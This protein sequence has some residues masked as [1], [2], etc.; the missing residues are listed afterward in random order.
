[1]LFMVRLTM[2]F[3]FQSVAA[4]A[5]LLKTQF[6]VGLAEIG[7]LIGLYFTPGIVLAL[8]G[9][10]IGQRL[11][12]KRTTLAALL[13]MLFGSMT[14][15][16]GE[17]WSWQV[18][19]RLIAG[20]GGVLL[21]VQMTKMVADWFAGKEIATAMAIFVNSWPAGIALSLLALPSIGTGYG[22]NAVHLFVAALVVIGIA[23]AMIYQP[24]PGV[25]AAAAASARPD[26]RTALVVTVAG[27][28]WGLFNVGFAVVFSFG[29]TMLVER[30]WTIARAGSVISIVLWLAVISVPMGGF[31]A[32]RLKRPQTVLVVGSLISAALMLGLAHTGAVIA[33]VVAL[34]LISGQPAG[35]IMS[36][37]ARVLQPHTRAIGMGVFYAIYYGIM[38]LGPIIAGTCAKWTGEAA[39]AFDFGALV[40]L[41]C[42]PLLWAFNRIAAA[43]TVP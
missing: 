39:S 10:A 4:V 20:G 16:L 21:N 5:P 35:P 17:S 1:M 14:M 3:Q 18:A 7:F 24:P 26:F 13:L 6:S 41:A 25:A 9:G 36:L 2:A 32:D 43:R 29:P 33:G 19:G 12:D 42:P 8:P 40:M 34:G 11:G 22:I 23:L 37:P 27:L 30:G 28:I 15:A 38:A 31:V